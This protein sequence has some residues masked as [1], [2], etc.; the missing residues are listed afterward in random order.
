MKKR[1]LELVMGVLLLLGF[2]FLSQE[3][4]RMVSQQGQS[5]ACVVLDAGHGGCR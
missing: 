5:G 4:A 1:Y 3:G 2:F